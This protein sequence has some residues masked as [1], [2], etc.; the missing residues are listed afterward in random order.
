MDPNDQTTLVRQLAD[1]AGGAKGPRA[2]TWLLVQHG[3]LLPELIRTGIIAALPNSGTNYISWK[4]AADHCTTSIP[5][6]AADAPRALDL[7]DSELAI[8]K[9]ACTLTGYHAVDLYRLGWLDDRNRDLAAF[10]FAWATGGREYAHG[11]GLM[12][13]L[14]DGCSWQ[15]SYCTCPQTAPEEPQPQT[16][17]PSSTPIQEPSVSD[18]TA[19]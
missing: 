11:L 15:P 17:A 1:S 3:G 4:A 9:L 10:A 6:P 5:T 8:L 7:T 12:A 16:E 18:H 14:C 13:G 2:A 19:N